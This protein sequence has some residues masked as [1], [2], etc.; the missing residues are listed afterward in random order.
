M[1]LLF[2]GGYG[3]ISW[4]CTKQ[5][6]ELGHEVWI[7]NRGMTHN[8]RRK[9]PR[10]VLE[11]IADIRDEN[12]VSTALKGMEF[13]VVADFIC[14]NAQHALTDVELFKNI[15]KQFIF[16]SSTANYQKPH[17]QLPYKEDTPLTNCGWDYSKNKIECEKVFLDAFKTQNFPVTIVRPGHTYDTLIPE[18][19]GN[20]DWTVAN[21]ILE[22]KPIVVHGD[23]STLWTLTHAEDFARAFV[24][25]LGN[26]KTIGEAYHITSD[27]WLT[28]REITQYLASALGVEKPKV[29]YIPS[30]IIAQ[31]NPALGIGLL[32]HKT[33]CDIY[34]NSKIKSIATGWKA[35]IK[36]KNGIINTINWLKEDSRRQRVNP[37]LDSFIDELVG[38]YNKEFSFSKV[39]KWLKK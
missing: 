18:A 24:C 38:E 16:I 1:K 29:V 28:W 11:I 6:L 25:L 32:G 21:R 23:G 3:N 19:V 20:G 37:A 5:A 17:S 26:T 36:F 39:L 7:L 27:E 4:H 13:D 30:E 2:I 15:A 31:N 14:Y 8:S 35:E 9:P 10:G 34:D 12:A 22:N 33:W